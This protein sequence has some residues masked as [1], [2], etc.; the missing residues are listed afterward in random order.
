MDG[1]YD[2]D[3][4]GLTDRYEAKYGSDPAK[5]D[6]DDD[7]IS[8]K[9]EVV[10]GS[11]PVHPM[12]I[13]VVKA[14][15]EKLDAVYIAKQ[16]AI[17]TP[18]LAATMVSTD[19]TET[20]W[21]I[22]YTETATAK[23]VATVTYLNAEAADANAARDKYLAALNDYDVIWLMVQ[24]GDDP[25]EYVRNFRAEG[26]PS[27]SLNI[28]QKPFVDG[29][30]VTDYAELPH[31]D[32]FA[33]GP[34]VINPYGYNETISGDFTLEMWVKHD[35]ASRMLAAH[36]SMATPDWLPPGYDDGAPFGVLM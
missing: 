28:S 10:F 36:F 4:D 8:D 25:N 14:T 3:G 21:N 1:D 9:L 22:T 34:M 30:A 16:R 31:P 5:A 23:Q 6:T 20:T 11:S 32:R 2:S 24:H 19:G 33:V 12:S 15:G 18:R 13:S 26:A 35:S 7:G 17:I 27:L 29:S